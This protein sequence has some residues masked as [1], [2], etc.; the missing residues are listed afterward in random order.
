[1]VAKGL[2]FHISP[3]NDKTVSSADL[4]KGYVAGTS[5]FCWPLMYVLLEL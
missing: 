4:T 3:S 2:S 5:H 1:M